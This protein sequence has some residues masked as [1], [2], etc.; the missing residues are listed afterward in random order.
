[1]RLCR[2]NRAAK[3]TVR[4]DLQD[5]VGLI[6]EKGCWWSSNITILVISTSFSYTLSTV[7]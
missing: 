3:V 2:L 5:L 4:S 1:M 6:I 7:L